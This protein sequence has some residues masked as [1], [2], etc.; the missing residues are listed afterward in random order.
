MISTKEYSL[1]IR[2]LRIETAQSRCTLWRCTCGTYVGGVL[3]TERYFG[4]VCAL[5]DIRLRSAEHWGTKDVIVNTHILLTTESRSIFWKDACRSRT[6]K[7]VALL[8]YQNFIKQFLQAFR[9][10][11]VQMTSFVV[12]TRCEM[13]V[14]SEVSDEF[15]ASMF[16][17]VTQFWVSL[18]LSVWNNFP[19]IISPSTVSTVI[20]PQAADTPSCKTSKQAYYSTR[21]NNPHVHQFT[22]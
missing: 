21:C 10:A 13:Q 9:K 17:V 18:L 15:D 16:K 14:C 7:F 11:V 8:W 4:G 12:V 6:R 20:H 19:P 1:H 5:G 22:R 3:F 2:P